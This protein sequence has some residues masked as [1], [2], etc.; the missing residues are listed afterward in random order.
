YGSSYIGTEHLLLGIMAQGASVGAKILADAG[1]TLD[2]A[3]SALDAVP[4]VNGF[5]PGIMTKSLSETAK[6]TLKMSWDAAQEFHHEHLGTEHILYSLL[7]QKNARATVL[8]RDMNID[9]SEV[10]AELEDYLDRQKE[11]HHQVEEGERGTRQAG[12]KGALGVFGT[13]LTARA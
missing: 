4:V 10:L 7:S 8:L 1:V 2:R 13:D 11:T 9:I 3:Q 12:Q 6:L 5:T